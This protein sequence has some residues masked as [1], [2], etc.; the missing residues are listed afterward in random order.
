[1][2][3]STNQNQLESNDSCSLDSNGNAVSDV[4]YQ[5]NMKHI[6]I[7]EYKRLVES[8]IELIQA[9]KHIEKLTTIIQKKNNL[10]EKLEEEKAKEYEHLTSVSLPDVL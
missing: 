9:R 6:S 2:Y 7:G 8:S 4:L 3:Y 1:M 5:E 10:I